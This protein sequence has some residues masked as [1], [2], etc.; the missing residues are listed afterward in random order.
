M[1]EIIRPLGH[2]YEDSKELERAEY[3][4]VRLLIYGKPGTGQSAVA[5][6]LARRSG[7]KPYRAGQE[8]RARVREETGEEIIGHHPIGP[9]GNISLDQEVRR[10]ILDANDND[11][12]IV[13]AKLSNIIAREIE[14]GAL[15]NG[16]ESPEF[17]G[18]LFVAKAE[19][20]YSR[21]RE[22]EIKKRMKKTKLSRA[23]IEKLPEFSLKA[24]KNAT[25]ERERGNQAE[26]ELHHPQ[27]AGI[28]IF[29]PANKDN[30]GRK[31]FD[32]HV[33][34]TKLSIMEAADLVEAI[35]KSRYMEMQ[36]RKA[37][38]LPQSVVIFEA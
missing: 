28:D 24:I 31:I 36:K 14:E 15:K 29:N 4:P 30:N 27:I 26:W 33:N 35:L 37:K 25:L 10:E 1:K 2:E 9:E 21:I 8:N 18:I 38:E 13:D 17:I 3:Y 12:V 7:I 6:E 22:R 23:Q 5:E 20:R 32:F 19:V 16:E 34:T 11:K